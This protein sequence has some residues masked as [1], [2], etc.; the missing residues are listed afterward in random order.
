MLEHRSLICSQRSRF[1]ATEQYRPQRFCVYS[2]FDWQLDV[3]PAPRMPWISECWS[4]L[5]YAPGHFIRYTS[6]RWG[7]ISQVTKFLQFT[8]LFP[9]CTCLTCGDYQFWCRLRTAIS[10]KLA[11]SLG[12]YTVCHTCLFL[13]SG[14]WQ[15]YMMVGCS[16]SHSKQIQKN[17][18]AMSFRWKHFILNSKIAHIQLLF[19]Q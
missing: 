13:K 14:L 10:T 8:Q 7:K 15:F 6:T 18:F 2:T 4:C 11:S 17:S 12:L 9:C 16:K 19:P 1:G 3:T 5:L